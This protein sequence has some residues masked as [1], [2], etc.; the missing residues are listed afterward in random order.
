M[1]DYFEFENI[2]CSVLRSNLQTTMRKLFESPELHLE[3]IQEYLN[4]K[5]S[6][7]GG[8]DNSISEFLADQTIYNNAFDELAEKY[9]FP[10]QHVRECKELLE[11]AAFQYM[12]L[13]RVKDLRPQMRVID[14]KLSEIN[15]QVEVLS[16]HLNSIKDYK[17][18]LDIVIGTGSSELVSETQ[19]SLRNVTQLK[20]RLREGQFGS[21]T[22][23]G[24]KSKVGNLGLLPFIQ[25]NYFL[26]HSVLNR[27]I[28]QKYDGRSGRKQFFS[29]LRDCMRIIHP[30]LSYERLDYALKDAQRNNK[31]SELVSGK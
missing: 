20:S 19:E 23:L 7:I 24:N 8:N 18:L 9:E 11:L 2:D 15:K 17:G 28:K 14:K 5:I 10:S 27:T 4:R 31:V 30:A 22:Q 3:D 6:K 26:W 1:A 13:S 16:Y 29:F 21:M 25:I 12:T